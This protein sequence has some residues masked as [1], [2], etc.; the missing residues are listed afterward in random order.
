MDRKLTAILCSD[1]YGYS[2]LM[3]EDE[4]ATHRTL[5]SDGS[6]SLRVGSAASAG[7]GI[8]S[9]PSPLA[10][11]S[12]N[13]WSTFRRWETIRF[14]ISRFSTSQLEGKGVGYVGLL[15]GSLADIELERLTIVVGK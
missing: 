12:A 7:F 8:C 13:S 6:T 9:R 11:F 3:G 15:N 2:R 14:R 4:E 5:I 10:T 1:V